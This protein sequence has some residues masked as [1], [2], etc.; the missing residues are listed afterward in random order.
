MILTMVFGQRSNSFWFPIVQA[1][2]HAQDQFT[3][4]LEHGAT[5]PND[6]F[7]FLRYMPEF[8]CQLKTKAKAIREAQQSLIFSLLDA[9]KESRTERRRIVSRLMCLPVKVMNATRGTWH[10]LMELLRNFTVKL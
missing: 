10:I 6:V 5:P 2:Y 1:L 9:T 3:A 7:T 8:I 4:I